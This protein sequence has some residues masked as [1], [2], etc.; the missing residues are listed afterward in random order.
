M[1]GFV[2]GPLENIDIDKIRQIDGKRHPPDAAFKPE[3][4]N[5]ESA[6][7]SSY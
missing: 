5:R 3:L 4:G 2:E 7:N 6:E 1:I